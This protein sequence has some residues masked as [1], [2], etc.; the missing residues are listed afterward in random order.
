[1]ELKCQKEDGHVTKVTMSNV[2]YVPSLKRKLISTSE[3][4]K[5]GVTLAIDRAKLTVFDQ[6]GNAVMFGRMDKTGLY[7]LV[8]EDVQA[9]QLKE[10]TKTKE[11]EDAKSSQ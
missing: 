11:E 3:L 8:E 10:N 1:V 6:A 9:N 4:C 7:E 5:K 2:L